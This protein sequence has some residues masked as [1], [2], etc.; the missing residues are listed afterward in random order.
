MSAT[1]APTLQ[2]LPLAA[3]VA[4]RTNPRRHFAADKLAELTASIAASG[5]HQPILVRPLP[6]SRVQDTAEQRM[7]GQPLPAYELV[8]GE[9]RWRA[10]QNAGL[11]DIPAM[12][13]PLSDGEVLEIQIVEN[14]QRDDLTELEEAEGYHTLMHSTG[15]N[16]QQVGDKIG[17]SR[18]YVYGRLKLMDACDTVRDAL[19]AGTIEASRALLL[20]RIPTEKLQ[21]Q[22]LGLVASTEYRHVTHREAQRLVQQQFMVRLDRAVFDIA[23]ATLCPQAGAC[24]TCP[25]RTSADPDLFADHTGPDT[26]LDP[27]CYQAKTA[28]HEKAQ[29][30]AAQAAG[31][32]VLTGR[33]AKAVIPNQYG[34]VADGWLRLDNPSDCPGHKSTLRK[35]LGKRL[36]P[37]MVT[38]VLPSGATS[39]VACIPRPQALALLD[40]VHNDKAAEAKA[41]L[42][43]DQQRHQQQAKD[44]AKR[45]RKE[46]YEK[47]WRLDLLAAIW[48]QLQTARPAAE[49]EEQWCPADVLRHVASTY[50]NRL[51]E[52]RAT[53]LAKLLDLGKVAP[54]AGVLQW[55]HETPDPGAALMLLVA[56]ADAE[57]R[58]WLSDAEQSNNGLLLV[59]AELGLD[60]PAI[61]AKTQANQRAAEADKAKTDKAKKAQKTP[62]AAPAAEPADTTLPPGP[63]AQAHGIR[64][65]A[66]AKAKPG[67]ARATAAPAA[68]PRLSAQ[69]AQ[70]GIAAAM[71]GQEGAGPVDGAEAPSQ[72]QPQA[73]AHTTDALP[74]A[75]GRRVRIKSAD[76][77]PKHQAKWAGKEG[78]VGNKLGD[79]AWMVTLPG[80]RGVAALTTSVSFDPTEL[81]V[82]A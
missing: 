41:T 76:H 10:S 58:P 21:I 77:L 72:A 65:G 4:S 80:K 19:R 73:Q 69:E 11:A 53:R 12:V 59:A 42:Q 68:A 6:A 51:N 54:V 67:K 13:R 81:E 1:T 23:D 33:E 45:D 82:L 18:S 28:A 63:A 43:A 3:I 47:T 15:Q 79:R 36:L 64:G 78:T 61:Q 52:T 55:A 66:K 27:T 26:C 2:H 20:A 46:A 34:S 35:L 40:E 44:Q 39:P 32:T 74:L 38:L 60:V 17:K 48:Q 57:Y 37:S 49:P 9:R 24:S 29:L 5:V 30:A 75:P 50:A 56:E 16:A 31:A 14:L 62:P 8:A 71:Q 7:P 70:R 22:A 25:K